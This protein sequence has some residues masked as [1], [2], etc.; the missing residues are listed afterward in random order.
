[1]TIKVIVVGACGRMGREIIK[2]INESKLDL[3]GAVDCMNIGAD[4]GEIAGL[5]KNN[6][7]I[8]DK[9]LD[10]IE[11][12]DVII[13]FSSPEATVEHLHINKIKKP[14]VIGTTGLK[15]EEQKVLKE[16]SQFVPI[17]F[18]PN[19]SVGVNLLFKLTELTSKV[20]NSGFDV[21]IIE[22]HHRLKKDA[23][24]GTANKLLE[25]ITHQLK[26]DKEKD[27]VY[28]RCGMIGERKDSEIGVMAVRGGD[29]VGEHTVMFAGIGERLELIHRASSRQTFAKGA[30]R[31][32]QWLVLQKPGLYSMF[33]V[34]GL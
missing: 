17:V 2:V 10:V 3:A 20:L 18:S 1:M 16:A 4:S 30:V 31:A 29:I 15:E 9:F 14:V 12:G 21:E 24:S 25:I 7:L 28:G 34:L 6:I 23:P 26:R 11:N 27:A 19:M 32:A 8:T 22:A 5:G 33:D 13:E